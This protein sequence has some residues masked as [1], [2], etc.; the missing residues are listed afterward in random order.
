MDTQGDV[1]DAVLLR[2]TMAVVAEMDTKATA[3]LAQDGYKY[4]P[5]RRKRGV[6]TFD[7]GWP[8]VS[9]EMS[10]RESEQVAY[11]ELFA[12]SSDSLHPFAYSD[13]ETLTELFAYVEN[14]PSLHER[15]RPAA[16]GEEFGDLKKRM[17]DF[18]VVNLPTSIL[19]RAKAL[20]VD[21][22]DAKV[23]DLYRLREMSWLAPELHYQ[24]VAPLVLTDLDIE[25]P[26]EIDE[27]T[28]IEVL[29]DDDLRAMATDYDISGVPRPVGDAAKFAVVVDMPPMHNA[30]E[31]QR[32]LNR[33]EPPDTTNIEAVCEAMRIVSSTPTGWARVFRRPLGWAERWQDA[34]PDLSPV[35]TARRYPSSFDDYGW[36][37]AGRRVT[38][39][40]IGRLSAVATALASAAAP[41]RLAARRL[42][43]A[44]VRDT[45]DDQLVDAC[46]GL[47]ALLGQRGAELS[48]R[49]ALRAAA[50]LSSRAEDPRAPEVVFRIARK[51][52][53]RRSELVHGST[54]SKASVV[55][56]R[57]GSPSL[58][59]HRVAVWLLRDVLHERLL[60]SDSWTVE[61]LDA[62]MIERLAPPS[63]PTD[64]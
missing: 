49:I 1:L 17:V 4:V 28:R 50:L 6:S 13:V 21:G 2:L 7:S 32:L 26:L 63:T 60:R 27:H 43:M 9:S 14:T 29:A 19:D 18:T 36:L 3:Y 16:A 45:P 38:R 59:T 46:I 10:G 30:G 15:L 31:W 25:A 8:N 41:T 56:A 12:F 24:L 52:Y 57:E 11:G 58:P 55:S 48:Y 35:H 42:S 53:E 20:G 64:S 61:D 47:E 23:V 54:S 40:E 62:L 33:E 37:K 51:V 34:L 39:S 44:Q 22:S 5:K